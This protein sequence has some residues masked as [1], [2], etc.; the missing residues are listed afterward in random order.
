MPQSHTP[1][2][3]AKNREVEDENL[4]AA[5]AGREPRPSTEPAGGK[6]STRTAKTATDPGSGKTR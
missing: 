3:R 2:D 1:G 5:P 6:A 4:K